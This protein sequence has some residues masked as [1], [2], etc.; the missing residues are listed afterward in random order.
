MSGRSVVQ[1]LPAWLQ[2]RL[3]EWRRDWQRVRIKKRQNRRKRA[4]Y[5]TKFNAWGGSSHSQMPQSPLSF[6]C[7]ASSK[8]NPNSMC[9]S[10]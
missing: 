3:F 10:H 9:L 6:Q 1:T 4:S 2:R 8:G 7:K 5:A